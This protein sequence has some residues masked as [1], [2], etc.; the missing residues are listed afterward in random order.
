MKTAYEQGF[1]DATN[2][3]DRAITSALSIGVPADEQVS[4]IIA[5]THYMRLRTSDQSDEHDDVTFEEFQQ[6]HGILHII[7]G[8]IAHE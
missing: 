7:E 1:L 3:L 4:R 8:G 5:H 6:Q 2:E